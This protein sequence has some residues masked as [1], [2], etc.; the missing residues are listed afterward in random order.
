MWCLKG[1]YMLGRQWFL[2]T[3]NLLSYSAW[4]DYIKVF[5]L[6]QLGLSAS[7]LVQKKLCLCDV[8]SS[9][10]LF[11]HILLM[12]LSS[13]YQG[14][15]YCGY[16]A[17]WSWGVRKHQTFQWYH[18]WTGHALHVTDFHTGRSSIT[19]CSFSYLVRSLSCPFYWVLWILEGY[20]ENLEWKELRVLE[21][22]ISALP[23]TVCVNLEHIS[24]SVCEIWSDFAYIE[25]LVWYLP[26]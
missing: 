23:F 2:H 16:T 17:Y 24:S 14:L 22:Q 8:S 20:T 15:S 21:T 5:H 18:F 9:G 26:W 4:T 11:S 6:K 19:S 13:D 1:G 12:N 3:E 25:Y 10:W 7:V